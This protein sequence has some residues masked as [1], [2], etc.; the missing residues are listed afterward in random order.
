MVGKVGNGSD[1]LQYY[2]SSSYVLDKEE[3]SICVFDCL[4]VLDQEKKISKLIQK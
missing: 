4:T 2:D 3:K 1:F